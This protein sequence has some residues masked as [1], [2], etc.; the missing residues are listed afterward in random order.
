V[1]VGIGFAILIP[2]PQ[3]FAVPPL[4]RETPASNSELD[5][6]RT[7]PQWRIFALE[8]TARTATS[9]VVVAILASSTIT[10]SVQ[11]PL[12]IPHF[13]NFQFLTTKPCSGSERYRDQNIRKM[14]NKFAVSIYFY[15]ISHVNVY[16]CKKKYEQIFLFVF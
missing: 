16:T 2:R 12:K 7:E 6:D 14:K 3:T 4:S 13:Q 9:I 10:H 8:A 1:E 5:G 15:K 11:P